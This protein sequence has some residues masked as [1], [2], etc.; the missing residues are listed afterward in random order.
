M[1]RAGAKGGDQGQP[2]ETI[3]VVELGSTVLERPNDTLPDPRAMH[4]TESAIEA[5]VRIPPTAAA[6]ER[7]MSGQS[8]VGFPGGPRPKMMAHPGG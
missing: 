8:A 1:R 4:L 5:S 6:T 2:Y 7:G 3:S